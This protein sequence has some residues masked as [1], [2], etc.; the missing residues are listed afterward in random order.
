M[1]RLGFTSR[2]EDL[3]DF[4]HSVFTHI[5]H[6]VDK[7]ENAERKKQTKSTKPKRRR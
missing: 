7:L 5:Q 4:D 3:S 2:F 6:Q 1:A